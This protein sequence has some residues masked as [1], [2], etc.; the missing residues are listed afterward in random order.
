[1]STSDQIVQIINELLQK[2]GIATKPFIQEIMG[3][4][5]RYEL[6][7]SIIW[8]IVGIVLIL[9]SIWALRK[10]IAVGQLYELSYALVCVC[11]VFTC[12]VAGIATIAQ[13]LDIIACIT[14]P[15]KILIKYIQSVI[16]VI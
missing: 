14:F 3:K 7:S 12:L 15:E 8:M 5:V 1:M 6:I 2:N 16:S 13:G 11:A 9:C 4:I 10:C